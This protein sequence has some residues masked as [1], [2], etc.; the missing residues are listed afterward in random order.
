MSPAVWSLA[1]GVLSR[2]TRQGVQLFEKLLDLPFGASRCLRLLPVF[3]TSGK[4]RTEDRLGFSFFFLSLVI[5]CVCANQVPLLCRLGLVRHGMAE[6]SLFIFVL[7]GL[8]G[9]L[10]SDER[11]PQLP[12]LLLQ[13]AQR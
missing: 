6:Q 2:G 7:T 5:L 4:D 3:V 1:T 11:L 10:Q 12:I 9:D 8:A 13:V